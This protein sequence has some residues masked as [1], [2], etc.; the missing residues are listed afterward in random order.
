MATKDSRRKM[1]HEQALTYKKHLEAIQNEYKQLQGFLT[2]IG[3][4]PVGGWSDPLDF[5]LV[6]GIKVSDWLAKDGC[7]E[8]MVV[9]FDDPCD[10]T[11][12]GDD[13]REIDS[14]FDRVSFRAIP[15]DTQIL[16]DTVRSKGLKVFLMR[17]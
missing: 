6:K 10:C 17:K 14:R 5:S 2:E 7:T 12:C 13:R 3:I 9:C 4:K 1:T 11:E 16:V 8:C 15:R